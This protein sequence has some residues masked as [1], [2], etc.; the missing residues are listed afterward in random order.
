MADQNKR[1]FEEIRARIAALPD[2]LGWHVESDPGRWVLHGTGHIILKVRKSVLDSGAWISDAESD[3][4]VNAPADL[5]WL[6]MELTSAANL[7]MRQEQ[8]IK[9]LDAKLK[10]REANYR[11][12]TRGFNKMWGKQSATIGQLRAELARERERVRAVVKKMHQE[13]GR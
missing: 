10:L 7:V 4:I 2:G 5:A 8:Q 13:R 3:L 11:E 1:R 12:W 6:C 9:A